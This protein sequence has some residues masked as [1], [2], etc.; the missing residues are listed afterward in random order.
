MKTRSVGLAVLL[1]VASLP[2]LVAACAAGHNGGSA[3]QTP[4]QHTV[5]TARAPTAT[6]APSAL[7]AW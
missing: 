2:V 7:S 3:P 5:T 6:A 1:F 4:G